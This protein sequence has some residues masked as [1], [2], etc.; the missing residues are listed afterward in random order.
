MNYNK[1]DDKNM[2]PGD[3]E[4]VYHYLANLIEELD[5]VKMITG[6]EN[7]TAYLH[8]EIYGITM[9]LRLLYPGPGN[10]GEKAAFLVRPSITE[11]RCE[12]E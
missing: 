8:G 5:N 11:H 3:A 6:S 10:W 9:T 2:A 12:C 7:Y 4:K 1:V